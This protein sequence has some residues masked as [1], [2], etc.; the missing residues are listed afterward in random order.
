MRVS[1][2][3]VFIYSVR[4]CVRACMQACVRMWLQLYIFANVRQWYS[5]YFR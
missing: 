3:S 5:V 1:L 4:A 2:Y